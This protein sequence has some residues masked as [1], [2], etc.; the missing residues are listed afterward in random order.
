MA[1]VSTV[2]LEGKAARAVH[3]ALESP[4]TRLVLSGAIVVS[5]LP[6]ADE[7]GL[8][9]L[10]FAL[11]AAEFAL[12]LF[13]T[14]APPMRDGRPQRRS[15]AWA[16]LA[17]DLLALLSFLPLPEHVAQ[18]RWLRL[19]R[20]SRMLLLAGY[21]APLA[22]DLWGIVSRRERARQVVWMGGVV[23]L[24]SFAGAAVLHHLE[25]APVDFDGDGALGPGDRQ[26]LALLWWSFRQI[27]DPGNMLASPAAV[28]AV[29]VS[30]A[31]TVFGLFLVS[32]LIGLGTD[33]VRELLELSQIRAPGLR[34]HTVIVHVD[35]RTQRLLW[36]LM[37]Y[38]R[39]LLPAGARVLSR[40]WWR[41]LWFE[42]AG[43]WGARY[44][45]VGRE[46]DAPSFLH[47]PGLARIVYRR[48][49]DDE[50]EF[51][52]R[53]DA[54]TAR[55]IL[56][57]A[58]HEDD[59]PDPRTIESLFFLADALRP[60]VVPGGRLLLAEI[61]H[62]GHIAP[63]RAAVADMADVRGFVVPT[64]RLVG[65]FLSA[66]LR[67][68]GLGPLLTELL[69][70]HGHEMYTCIF[71]MRGLSYQPACPA[72]L[73]GDPA[74]GLAE[75]GRRGRGAPSP[76]L[77]V[78]LLMGQRDGDGRVVELRPEF[79]P[80]ATQAAKS[81]EVVGFV[82]VAE[83][84][85]RVRQLVA[86]A[87]APAP[88][89]PEPDPVPALAPTLA[90]RLRTLVLCGFRDGTA[91]LLADLLR[92]LPGLRVLV[93]VDDA[94]RRQRVM[95]AVRAHHL[96]RAPD[97]G[98]G[99]G[100]FRV[101]ADEV[102][103]ECSTGQGEIHVEDAD[104]AAS[105]VLHELPAGFGPVTGVDALL[106][107]AARDGASDARI[108]TS[109]LKV[110]LL[111]RAAGRGPRV[112][113]EVSESG[114]ARRLRARFAPREGPRAPGTLDVQAYAH[115]DLRAMF[116][117]QSVVVPGFERVYGEL[118]AAG[119]ASFERRVP[120]AAYDGPATFVALAASLAAAGDH[121]IAVEVGRPGATPRLCV[122]PAPGQPGRRFA[123]G[124]LRA[125]WVVRAGA[126]P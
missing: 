85:G 77:P 91:H 7:A 58:D 81:R 123:P 86:S 5:L 73:A 71:R 55:R 24:L 76:V 42:R 63:A 54:R 119:G 75:L 51:L 47:A 116:L 11:F 57:L 93:L 50:D 94:A 88:G 122:A 18:T 34:G 22:H 27:Q 117:F 126:R 124:S 16:L 125:V 83:H 87:A 61:V 3:D 65:L 108:T 99:S 106:Y 66:V 14:V 46:R 4:L 121:L 15:L 44:V 36:E 107:V 53:V 17:L 69:S 6:G 79:A 68:P 72:W 95:D 101:D 113:A 104:W 1:G 8:S 19:F 45:V 110:E 64:E 74:A 120:A 109:L 112:V 28:G 32:F 38:Y 37:R 82:A 115:D 52:R 92:A 114:L 105:D 98:A 10:F 43:L 90:P 12:R 62:E 49:T 97:D 31:L 33:V 78:A 25:R 84:F 48:H 111:A 9:A 13:V 41:R 26:F 96:C 39:K 103:F 40:T 102:R 20:L 70:S 30:L 2:Q 67:N 23:A 35:A 80:G 60:E 118:L 21:W 56:L 100:V 89:E 59:D 29:A